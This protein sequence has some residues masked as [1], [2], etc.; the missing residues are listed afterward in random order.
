MPADDLFAWAAQE[1]GKSRAEPLQAACPIPPDG[2][3][4]EATTIFA[5]LADRRGAAS[6]ITAPDIARAAGLWP[7]LAPANRGNKVRKL[8]EQTQD[9]WPFPIC[10]DTT[11]YYVAATPDE[12]T[13]YSANLRSRAIC[14]LR[15]FASARRAGIRAGF[16]YHGKGRWSAAG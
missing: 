5:V 3:S 11:G 16:V 9:F 15:R 1:A 6:A 13:H 12:L 2:F 10:G 8:L 4:Q 14:C 7:H